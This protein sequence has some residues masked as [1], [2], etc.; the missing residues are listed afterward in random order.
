MLKI[1]AREHPTVLVHF[2][3]GHFPGKAQHVE[4]PDTYEFSSAGD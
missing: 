1:R 3:P 4:F 2:C